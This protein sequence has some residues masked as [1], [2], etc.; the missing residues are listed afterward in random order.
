MTDIVMQE[1]PTI[2][3]RCGKPDHKLFMNG[4]NWFPA[5]LDIALDVLRENNRVEIIN[6]NSWSAPSITFASA[7]ALRKWS[8]NQLLGNSIEAVLFLTSSC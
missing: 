4:L 1:R 6:C 2:I 7:D 3:N 5:A 8:D